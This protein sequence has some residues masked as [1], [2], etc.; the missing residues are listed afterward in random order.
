MK[1]ISLINKIILGIIFLSQ[2][3]FAQ[4]DLQSTLSNLS[5]DAAKKY[6]EPI[7]SSF[8]ANL[9]S[10][11]VHKAPSASLFGV[12]IEIGV[13]AMATM[14]GNEQKNFSSTGK[15]RFNDV[16]ATALVDNAGITNPYARNFVINEIKKQDFGVNISGP[17]IVGSKKE[18]VEVEFQGATFTDNLTGQSFTVPSKQIATVASGFLDEL[19]AA[20]LGAPQI[21]IGTIY[22]TLASF[23]YLPSIEVDK[24]LGK[25]EYF[26]FGLQHNPSAWLPIP[27]PVDVSLAYFTQSMKV[28]KIFDASA[29]SFGIYASKRI[30]PGALNITPYA[31]FAI[32]SSEITIQYDYV[33]DYPVAGT[34]LPVKFNLKG[35]NSSRFVIG[36][37][38]KLAF[39]NL[40]VDYSFAK[41]KTISGGLAFII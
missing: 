18:F 14:F 31:G 6:V 15:F 1:N 38:L 33:V 9:N 13:V 35:E 4:N 37:A 3:T 40:N 16:Q 23:R 11:W 12:D 10:G 26:G 30:G 25:F 22:G 7:S 19:P 2:I 39:L 8:G 27:L 20:P 36:A 21:T 34:V 32:E 29:T 5:A 17:T 28:G 24:D 41:Y